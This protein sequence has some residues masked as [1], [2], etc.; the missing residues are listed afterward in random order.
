MYVL[1]REKLAKNI[2]FAVLLQNKRLPMYTYAMQ[3][4]CITVACPVS[5]SRNE[6]KRGVY[7]MFVELQS[8]IETEAR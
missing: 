8:V 5:K 7:E 4:R 1:V 3:L 6:I 2:S